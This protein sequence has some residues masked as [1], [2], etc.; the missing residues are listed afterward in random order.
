MLSSVV[1]FFDNK[2][3]YSGQKCQKIPEI[4]IKLYGLKADSLDLSYN[5]LISLEG[6]EGFPSL[7]ELVLDN[8]QLSDSLTFPYIPNLQTLS[9]N[10]NNIRDLESIILKITQ[11]CP[12]IIY[13]SLLGNKA[14]PNK[15]SGEE[16][17]E[18]DYQRYYVLFHLPKL[19]FLDS[20]KVCSSER[21]EALR[22][23]KFMGVIRPTQSN[24]N[25]NAVDSST[26]DTFTP[27]PSHIR[28]AADHRGAYGKCRYRY[29]GK[30]SEGNRFIFNTDL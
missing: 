20:T 2:L 28:S 16:N 13:L 24:S 11:K 1:S 5:E 10:K 18:E 7:T 26:M 15:L 6:L 27:L 25:E 29:S 9:L 21:T 23:G 19:K 30:H 17:D 4:L 14:C 12:N 3:C 8:N 22:R